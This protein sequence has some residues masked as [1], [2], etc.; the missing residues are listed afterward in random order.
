L[1]K[2]VQEGAVVMAI[3]RRAPG[4]YYKISKGIKTFM[5]KLGDIIVRSDL[6]DHSFENSPTLITCQRDLMD[7]IGLEKNVFCT[8]SQGVYETT[9]V[10]SNSLDQSIERLF[11]NEKRLSRKHGLGSVTIRLPE[12]NTEVSGVYYYILK[13]LAWGGINIFE[14]ISTT[15]EVSIVVEE[16]DVHKAF[17]ILLT[18]KTKYI[19][20]Y[21]VI[22]LI[23][24]PD[25]IRSSP[26]LSDK[27]NNCSSSNYTSAYERHT[28]HI[29]LRR[30]V[31]VLDG[32]MGTMI[33]QYRLM[34]KISAQVSLHPI[35]GSLKGNNDILNITRPEIICAIHT[36]IS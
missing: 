12:D 21:I 15:N 14:I 24:P 17:P 1:K 28:S 30:K 7:E 19:K 8:F 3:N 11:M 10:A 2:P 6:S 5:N 16:K 29:Q 9:I 35:T 20:F 36:T 25:H 13:S 34:K 31:L 27:L 26:F 33:Q 32:A 18:E 22:V 4:Y 23:Q